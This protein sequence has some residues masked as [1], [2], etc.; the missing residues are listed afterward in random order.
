MRSQSGERIIFPGF[1]ALTIR[2]AMLFGALINAA[3]AKDAF[4]AVEPLSL[5]NVLTKD[6]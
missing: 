4:R 5:W 3:K 6:H 2:Y 1:A